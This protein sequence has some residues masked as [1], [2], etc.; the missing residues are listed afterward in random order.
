MRRSE[1]APQ[2]QR[3]EHSRLGGSLARI[4]AWSAYERLIKFLRNI[5]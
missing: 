2:A 3:S 1:T 5:H 4:H